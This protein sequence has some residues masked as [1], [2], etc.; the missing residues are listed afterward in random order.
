MA[1]LAGGVIVIWL[2]L[3]GGRAVLTSLGVRLHSPASR[4]APLIPALIE[5]P[6]FLCLIPGSALLPQHQGWPVA[7]ALTLIA[8]L[9]G[10]T[11]AVRQWRSEQGARL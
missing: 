4:V 5:T 6:L 11:L 8:W 1:V 9:V 7:I 3:S 2:G 10:I